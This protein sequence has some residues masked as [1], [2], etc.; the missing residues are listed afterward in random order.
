M[1]AASLIHPM[2]GRVRAVELSRLLSGTCHRIPERCIA[3]PWGTSGLCARCTAFWAGMALLAALPELTRRRIG[4]P[5]SVLMLV[6]MT[7]DG[8]MQYAGLY[9]STLLL[10]I[11]TGS[12]AGAGFSLLLLGLADAVGKTS[13]R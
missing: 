6:P 12:L 13:L 5:A 3:L 4:F 1:A 9:E 11:V 2:L 8:L 10:R 7:A